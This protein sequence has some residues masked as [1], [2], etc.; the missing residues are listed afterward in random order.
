VK[1]VFNGKTIWEGNVEVFDLQEHPK[2]NTTYAWSHA[3]DAPQPKR[4]VTVLHIPP[5]VCPE[6]A[7]HGYCSGVQES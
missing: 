2:A 4:H 5:A 3:T 7:V 1:E 6:T